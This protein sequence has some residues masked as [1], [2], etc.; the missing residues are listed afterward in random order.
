MRNRATKIRLARDI[1]KFAVEKTEIGDLTEE[2]ITNICR[3]ASNASPIEYDPKVALRKT[4]QEAMENTVSA[5]AGISSAVIAKSLD[6]DAGTTA[7]VGI[8]V[9]SVLKTAIRTIANRIKIRRAERA[10][11]RAM[12]AAYAKEQ[13]R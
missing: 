6:L 8:A 2:A 10:Y 5:V 7:T 9:T 12:T 4:A 11:N 1:V 13:G 3:A